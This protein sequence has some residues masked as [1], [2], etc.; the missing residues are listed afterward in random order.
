YTYDLFPQS[1]CKK[2]DIHNWTDIIWDDVSKITF[3]E[4]VSDIAKSKSI[5]KLSESFGNNEDLTFKW[6]NKVGSFIMED[7]VNLPL[8]EKNAIIPNENGDFLIKSELFIDQIKDPHLIEILQFLGEDWN[9]ILIH[10]KVG[11]GRFAVKKKSEIATKINE[12]LKNF[13]T[14]NQNFIKAISLLSEWFDN[15]PDEG[16]ELFMETY[17]KRAELFMNTI[18]DKDSLYKVMRSKTDLAHLSKVAEAIEENP[19][20]FENIEQAKEIYSLLK[21][22]NVNDLQQLRELLDSHGSTQ[23]EQNSLL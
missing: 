7:E 14:K 18:E 21:Q 3:A 9:D 2:D 1:V 11:F 13:S 5:S 17:R 23:I 10:H 4:L 12:K 6:F 8:F 19:R 15:N 16:K 22:Y 20:L